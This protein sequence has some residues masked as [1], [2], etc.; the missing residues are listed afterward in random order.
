MSVAA[1]AAGTTT[2]LLEG[3][4]SEAIGAGITVEPPGGSQQPTSDPVV[5][6][7]FQQT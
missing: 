1:E 3:D 4:A 5:L 2:A 6:F 7:D